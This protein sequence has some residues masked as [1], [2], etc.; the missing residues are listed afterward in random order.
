MPATE[1]GPNVS[2][3]ATGTAATAPGQ[4]QRTSEFVLAR[5]EKYVLPRMARALPRWIKPDHLTTL[6]LL[7]STG[8][9][10]SYMLTNHSP[11]W[12]WLAV[13]GSRSII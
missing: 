10:V 12:L 13:A 4:H 1:T 8:I 3:P 11:H 7:S 6:G 5:F 9:A 2:S